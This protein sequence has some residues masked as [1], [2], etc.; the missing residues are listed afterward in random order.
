MWTTRASIPMISE[1]WYLSSRWERKNRKVSA[2][3]LARLST[4][5]TYRQRVSGSWGSILSR[6]LS[7]RC[8][9]SGVRIMAGDDRLRLSR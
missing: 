4:V 5:S 1:S 3:P 8:T 9:S 6:K 7:T 2:F